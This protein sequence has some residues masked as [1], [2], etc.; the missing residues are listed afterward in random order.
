[1]S[2]QGT[3]AHAIIGHRHSWTLTSAPIMEA[4]SSSSLSAVASP[5]AL[6]KSRFWV[7][8]NYQQLISRA[9]I[10]RSRRAAGGVKMAFEARLDAPG[11]AYL[12]SY[13]STPVEPGQTVQPFLSNSVLLAAAASA[14][15]LVVNASNAGSN[16]LLLSNA[17]LAP[18]HM[19]PLHVG[20]PGVRMPVLL[21]AFN[22][23]N[24]S[25]IIEID[26][27]RQLQCTVA[28]AGSPAMQS[29]SSSSSTGE[30][31]VRGAA[32][33]PLSTRLQQLLSAELQPA[34][35]KAAAASSLVPAALL[36]AQRRQLPQTA[37]AALGPDP[38]SNLSSGSG[39]DVS[40]Y[41]LHPGTLESCLQSSMLAERD[42]SALWL[43]AVQSLTL[44]L[45]SPSAGACRDAGDSWVAADFTHA[46]DGST[47]HIRSL[48]MVSSTGVSI[49]MRGGV[50]AADAVAA[51]EAAAA[52]ASQPALAAG[53][54]AAQEA[55][56]AAAASTAVAAVTNPLMQL[57]EAERGLFLQAQIM[58]EV[59]SCWVAVFSTNATGITFIYEPM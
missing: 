7:A 50:L 28:A 35:A 53:T 19:L 23:S 58:S 13:V 6:D 17:V 40:G 52:A 45:V 30:G 55:A 29:S 46:S 4:T 21:L 54:P 37:V 22:A 11:L 51:A 9:L 31:E 5:A 49:S 36:E 33:V 25:C 48:N 15:S 41:V 1:V 24:G 42:A 14:A 47:C 27:Q 20:Q 57:D 59:R 3:N 56:A 34:A 2:S 38:S 10:T 12:W 32:A 44:P 26:G 8:P 16:A 39:V 43:S 18:P